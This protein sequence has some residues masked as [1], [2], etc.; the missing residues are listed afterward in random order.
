MLPLQATAGDMPDSAVAPQGTSQPRSSL[1]IVVGNRASI[2]D[3]DLPPAS[4]KPPAGRQHKLRVLTAS[5]RQAEDDQEPA[6]SDGELRELMFVPRI[7]DAV[8]PARADLPV[9]S[10]LKRTLQDSPPADGQ[11][12]QAAP[13][14]A[15]PEKRQPPALL[16]PKPAGRAADCQ[17]LYKE[18]TR[19]PLADIDLDIHKTKGE[20]PYRCLV[21][22]QG[23]LR[24]W[25][26]TC[27]TW[28]ASSLCHKPLYFESVALERYGHSMG[29]IQPAVSGAHFFGN[30]ALLPYNVGVELPGE[31]IYPLGYYRPGSCARKMIHPFPLS[32]RGAVTGGATAAGLIWLIP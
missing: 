6:G 12:E 16:R 19:Q 32:L 15:L 9:R 21:P 11:A 14:E 1:N 30:L 18:L 28:K 24:L 2:R 17:R 20:L 23:G 7:D 5:H 31:C 27:F 10:A 25:S 26:P 4:A 29:L 3:A 22:E 13:A 8:E